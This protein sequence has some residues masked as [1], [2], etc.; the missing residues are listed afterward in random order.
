MSDLSE[1][2]KVEQDADSI[3]LLYRD[4]VYNPN[5]PAARFAEIIVGK[6]R[7]GPG[8]TIYQEFKNGHFIA[9]DQVVAQESSR[10]QQEAQQPKPKERRYSSKPF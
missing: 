1:S 6:N 8:G 3:V 4:G 5:G 9:V 10:M 7:F 2:G